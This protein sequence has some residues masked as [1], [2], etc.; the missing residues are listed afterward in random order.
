MIWGGVG[1]R[2]RSLSL[3]DSPSF[4]DAVNYRKVEGGGGTR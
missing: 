3:K 4:E 2:R 1:S